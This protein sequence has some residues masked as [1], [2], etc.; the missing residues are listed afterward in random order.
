MLDIIIKSFKK[1]YIYFQRGEGREKEG[2]K[3]QCARETLIS[4]LLCTPNLGP[5]LQPRQVPFGESNLR[6][7]VLQDD[8]QPAELYHSGQQ[9]LNFKHI[10]ILEFIYWKCKILFRESE[11]GREKERERNINVWLLLTRPQQGTWPAMQACVLTGN[12]TCGPS[13]R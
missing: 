2:E 6:P 7:F 4:C 8:T 9:S 11:E 3:H 5:G 10:Y 1:R 12:Q 13:V